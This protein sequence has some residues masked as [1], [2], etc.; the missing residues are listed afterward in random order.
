MVP[1]PVGPGPNKYE[2]SY[3][4]VEIPSNAF[5]SIRVLHYENIWRPYQGG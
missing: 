3:M 1:V 5:V 4:K 2:I